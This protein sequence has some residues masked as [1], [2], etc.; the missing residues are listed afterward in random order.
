MILVIGRERELASQYYWS[1]AL[2]IQFSGADWRF[3]ESAILEFVWIWIN[4]F[5]EHRRRNIRTQNNAVFG[6]D[7]EGESQCI[8]PRT[9]PYHTRV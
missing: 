3:G 2:F 7:I 4:M 5:N 6:K 9:G 1:Q 8:S